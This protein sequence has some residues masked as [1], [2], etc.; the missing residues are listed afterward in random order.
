MRTYLL[1]LFVFLGFLNSGLAQ[2]MG[3][4]SR[5]EQYLTNDTEYTSQYAEAYER[6]HVSYE[7]LGMLHELKDIACVESVAAKPYSCRSK[8]DIPGVT[9]LSYKC[10]IKYSVRTNKE[11]RE[12]REHVAV[13]SQADIAQFF[14]ARKA[15]KKEITEF[16]EFL[17][18]FPTCP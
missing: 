4:D 9:N 15:V 5:V 14:S 11:R 17:A 10:R 3:Y 7:N 18:H 6:S 13:A 2:S 8:N 16:K 12:I 1:S